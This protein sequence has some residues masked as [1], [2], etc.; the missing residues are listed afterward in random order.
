MNMRVFDPN[1]PDGMELVLMC[2]RPGGPWGVKNRYIELQGGSPYKLRQTLR[3]AMHKWQ[4]IQPL[5]QFKIC[6]APEHTG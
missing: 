1:R 2:R 6:W 5:L 4:H 3:A